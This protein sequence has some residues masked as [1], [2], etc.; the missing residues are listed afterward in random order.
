MSLYRSIRSFRL[1]S[2][3]CT[4]ALPLCT[5]HHALG[6]PSDVSCQCAR[7]CDNDS[8]SR[9]LQLTCRKDAAAGKVAKLLTADSGPG[10][11]CRR[12]VSSRTSA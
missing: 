5:C 9:S 11:A 10:A 7:I 4:D 3:P 1:P 2:S 12:G 8:R 6:E